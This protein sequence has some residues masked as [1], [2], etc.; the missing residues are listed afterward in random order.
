M[1]LA[2]APET[3]AP[4]F[5]D[6]DG[7][8]TTDGGGGSHTLQCMATECYEPWG[9][10]ASTETSTY[11]C[12][13]DLSND[14]AN[15]GT[16]G[17]ACL[18][19]VPINMT[20][21]CVS[22]TCQLQCYKHYSQATK[23]FQDWS[24]CNGRIEDGCEA[25]RFNDLKNCGQCGNECA[26]GNP[27]IGGKCGCPQGLALCNGKCVDSGWD[28]NNCG[29]CGIRC[30]DPQDACS[31][32]QPHSTY[33]CAFGECG[34]K[35]CT[36]E[37]GTQYVD[38]NQDL[39]SPACG[40]D[41]CEAAGLRTRENCGRCGNKCTGAEECVDEGAGYECAVPCE[42][43]GKAR[44]GNTCVDLLNDRDNCG[45]CGLGCRPPGFDDATFNEISSCKKGLCVYECEPGFGDCNGDPSDGC[46]TN[47]NKN[48]LNCGS[49]GNSC[50]VTAGQPCIEGKC[51]TVACDGGVPN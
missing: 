7:A 17:N 19:Y 25:D 51:L 3:P 16:C 33:G 6:P 1:D 23:S 32:L 47:V 14:K 8:S 49:C 22:G 20:G 29:G 13:T 41:G 30:E 40:G 45:T 43:A 50:N 34:K 9:T 38:C 39:D 12:G 24:D 4:S 27:C 35:K 31:P 26:P 21:S 2:S 10:C 18:D 15:C 37:Q 44:C 42:R 48:P 46:E 5:T 11:K 28:D 36:V